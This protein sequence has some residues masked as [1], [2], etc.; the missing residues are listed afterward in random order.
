MHNIIVIVSRF[1]PFQKC[2]NAKLAKLHLPFV[3]FNHI[4]LTYWYMY[5]LGL[6]IHHSFTEPE[7]VINFTQHCTPQKP[8]YRVPPQQ[9]QGYIFPI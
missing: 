2:I 3:R 1:G 6:Q 4:T 9:N 5:I 7:A 8:N